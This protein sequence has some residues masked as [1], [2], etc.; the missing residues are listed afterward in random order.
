LDPKARKKKL[1]EKTPIKNEGERRL[2]QSKG[3]HGG[4]VKGSTKRQVVELK[5]KSGARKK[6]GLGERKHQG[7]GG[8]NTSK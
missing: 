1:E 8:Q 7:H 5:K 2:G 3:G 4:V 6:I